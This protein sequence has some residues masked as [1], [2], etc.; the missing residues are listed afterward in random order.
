MVSVYVPSI[1]L[2]R[3]GVYGL[4]HDA[5]AT[6]S[7]SPRCTA[8]VADEPPSTVNS[9]VGVLSAAGLV[10]GTVIVGTSGP[11]ESSTYVEPAEQAETLP[12]ASV[13][14]A[15]TTVVESSATSTARPGDAK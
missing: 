2:V 3:F 1:S 9:H 13:A 10:G 7:M 15:Y 5:G 6:T 4:A 8:Q 11:V 14:V 12:A